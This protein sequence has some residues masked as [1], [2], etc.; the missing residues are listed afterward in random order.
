[1]S[2]AATVDADLAREPTPE[3]GA[4]DM[5]G[6]VKWSKIGRTKT[7]KEIKEGRL[8]ASYVGRKLIITP[9]NG[10]AYLRSLPTTRNA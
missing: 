2:P 6:W 4:F 7:F 1:M 5:R 9:E 8:K 10:R 3:P